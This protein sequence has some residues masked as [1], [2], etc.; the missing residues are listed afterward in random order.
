[1]A[2]AREILRPGL[3]IDGGEDGDGAVGGADA[4]GNAKARVDRFRKRGTVDGSVNGRHEG[5]VQLIAALFG[6]GKANEAAAV[7]GH[8]VDGVRGDFFGG[9]GE[10]AFVFAVLVVNE[11]DHAALP[12]FF[13]GFFNSG[14]M[15]TSVRQRSSLSS[16]V[17]PI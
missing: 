13:D 17:Y 9:H 15:G 8:E 11:D 2:G 6:E 5:Q 4:G 14:E 3:R 16:Q 1:M 7:L 10:V 12:N